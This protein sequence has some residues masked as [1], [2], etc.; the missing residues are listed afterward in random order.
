M[1]FSLDT[2]CE[3]AH[4][5]RHDCIHRTHRSHCSHWTKTPHRGYRKLHNW[6]WRGPVLPRSGKVLDQFQTDS[7]WV[8]WF[9]STRS[10]RTLTELQ[11]GCHGAWSQGN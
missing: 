3:I 2:P 11:G 6:L 9:V 1:V 8:V 5:C 7:W 10:L 4:P